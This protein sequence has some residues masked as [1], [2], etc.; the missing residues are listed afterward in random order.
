MS[1]F[2]YVYHQSMMRG[3]CVVRGFWTV[4][5]LV[6]VGFG[7]GSASGSEDAER[8]ATLADAVR[9]VNARLEIE[10]VSPG[11]IATLVVEVRALQ[12]RGKSEVE[13]PGARVQLRAFGCECQER[14]GHADIRGRVVFEELP[15]GLYVYGVSMPGH[16][17][18]VG[19]VLL[20]A[21]HPERPSVHRVVA[22]RED[23]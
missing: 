20:L 17:P 15:A 18:R 8:R 19:T 22:L 3:G 6:A 7:A 16:E 4:L 10:P 12:A 21:A 9:D 14:D 1:P 5:L 2:L 13:L 11:S 23:L